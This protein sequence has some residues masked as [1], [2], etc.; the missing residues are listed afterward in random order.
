MVE[1]GLERTGR[2]REETDTYSELVLRIGAEEVAGAGIEV[3]AV[4]AEPK[5]GG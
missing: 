4:T 5:T 1:P 3:F 2:R